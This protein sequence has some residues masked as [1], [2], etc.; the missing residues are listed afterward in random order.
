MISAQCAIVGW[1]APASI[2]LAGLPAA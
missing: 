2:L 1:H